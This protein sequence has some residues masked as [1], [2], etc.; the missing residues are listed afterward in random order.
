MTEPTLQSFSP[1]IGYKEGDIITM[2][3]VPK[4]RWWQFWKSR[5]PVRE[6]YRLV[7]GEAKKLP[8]SNE[9]RA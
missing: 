3:S 4:R 1:S 9:G 5:E 2:W 7:G 8:R 6:V